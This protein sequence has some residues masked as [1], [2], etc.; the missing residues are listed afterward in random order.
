[1][2]NMQAAVYAYPWDLNDEGIVPALE[3]I[4]SLGL[5][6]VHLASSY[7]SGKFIS[8][9]SS[10]QR[11]Y[12]PEGGV[13]YFQPSE[14]RF[15]GLPIQPFVS[16]LVK[17]ADVLG[18]TADGCKRLALQFVAWVVGTH[19]TRIASSHPEYASRNAYGDPYIYALCPSHEAVREYVKGL[20]DDLLDQYPIAAIEMESFG[21]MGFLHGYH[22]EFYSVS[23]GAF[24]QSLLALCFCEACE[25]MG[26]EAGLDIK[27]LKSEIRSAV[28]RKLEE[29]RPNG[30]LEAESTA[31][32]MD[33]VLSRDALVAYLRKRS[34]LVTNLVS[35]VGQT[36]RNKG[37]K[38]YCLGPV[39]ARPSALG[40]VEG[41]D[42]KAIGKI[43]DRFE[44][45]LYFD[46]FERRAS[47]A[48]AIA[49]LGLPCG[50]GAAINAGHPYCRSCDDLVATTKLAKQAGFGAVGFYNYGTLP[51]YR[52]QWIEQ[53]VRAS[54]SQ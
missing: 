1:V 3:R 27:R 20:V 36:V 50:L 25:R 43:V 16:E 42:A 49:G 2:V 32:L 9:R 48:F 37:A 23:L 52:L 31:E 35:G 28:D 13:V 10:R 11:V 14:T 5:N 47:E 39:F 22:H 15:R 30:E 34:S 4:A 24:E 44:V 53:A 6:A 19:N 29:P 46:D 12:F 38:L 40:W 7:H 45:A 54:G 8:P 51:E 18:R 26:A 33:F 17:E 41:I 21:Y